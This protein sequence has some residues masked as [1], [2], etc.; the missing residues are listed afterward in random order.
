M[1]TMAKKA[2]AMGFLASAVFALAANVYAGE[3]GIALPPE[4]N[5]PGVAVSATG[6]GEI[7]LP[8]APGA[9]GEAQAAGRGN[10]ALNTLG[11]IALAFGGFAIGY[12]L[13]K[14]KL[15]GKK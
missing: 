3:G 9:A 13:G 6:G 15:G 1:G 5:A 8:P 4:Q 2:K 11:V 7:V 14:R 10:A 12:S